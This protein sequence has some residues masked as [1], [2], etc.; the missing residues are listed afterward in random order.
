MA[1]LQSPEMNPRRS[2]CFA[3]ASLTSANPADREA[4]TFAVVDPTRVIRLL[5]TLLDEREFLSSH[6]IRSLSAAHRDGV[7]IDVAGTQMSLHYTPGESDTGLFGGNSN[8]RGPIWFPLNTLLLD[9]LHTYATGAGSAVTIEFPTG[10]GERLGLHQVANRIEDR[11]VGLFR[12]GGDGRRPSDPR[13]VGT[14]PQ[15]A[16]TRHSA[17]TSTATPEP[18]WERRTRQGGLRWWPT[19]SAQSQPLQTRKSRT[20][21]GGVQRAPSCRSPHL[22][23]SNALERPASPGLRTH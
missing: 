23:S 13:D 18:A 21:S 14:G 16:S 11:L 7:S 3:G 1:A 8:W 12:P 9:A 6:G 2:R 20:P 19:S 22:P 17:S 4:L 5:E 10:S 15:W